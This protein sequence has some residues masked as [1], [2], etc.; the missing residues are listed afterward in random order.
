[1]WIEFLN[2]PQ[3]Q[4]DSYFTLYLASIIAFSFFMYGLRFFI[5]KRLPNLSKDFKE[6]QYM[7]LQTT[8]L[9]LLF[10]VF[11]YIAAT[12]TD[13]YKRCSQYVGTGELCDNKKGRLVC[14]FGYND[15]WLNFNNTSIID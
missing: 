5:E 10:T 7:A 15:S 12:Q 14:Q 8:V 6:V 2:I 1:M 9:F 3:G 13:L 4:V 11:L